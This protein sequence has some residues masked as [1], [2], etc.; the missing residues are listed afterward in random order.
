MITALAGLI[1]AQTASQTPTAPS[2]NLGTN[3][4]FQTQLKS[5]AQALS[6]GEFA[7]ATTAAQS[8]P[9]ANFTVQI[10]SE[11]LSPAEK[12]LTQSSLERAISAWQTAYPELKITLSDSKP[13][14]LISFVKRISEPNAAEE[15]SLALFP[16]DS[17][18]D[19]T[20]EAVIALQRGKTSALLDA[21]Q[22]TADIN[23]AIGQYLGLERSPVVAST[24]FRFEG[25]ANR[26]TKVDGESAFLASLNVLQAEQLRTWAKAKTTIIASFPEAFLREKSKDLGRFPQGEIKDFQFD[27]VNRGSGPLNFTIK[28]DCSCFQLAYDA[29]VP[30]NS[31]GIV[32]IRMH[33]AEFQGLQNKGLYFYTNDPSQPVTRVNIRADLVPAYRL[34]N[35]EN[36][37]DFLMS[38]NGLKTTYYIYGESKLGFE[39]R[40]ASIQGLNG[41]AEISPWTGE[42]EDP[43]LF[44]GKQ[45]VTGYKVE[46]L[47]SPNAPTGKNLVALIIRTDSEQFPTIA[48]N[49]TVQNGVAVTPATIF[50]GDVTTKSVQAS[51]I[52]TGTN[53]DFKVLESSSADS[54]FS[55][56][57]TALEGRN[58]RVEVTFQPGSTKGTIYSSVAL[59]TNDPKSPLITIPIQAYVK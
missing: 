27:V 48:A 59:K 18:T 25:L 5:T 3:E 34:I 20:L 6:Q 24:M 44:K 14:V 52:V 26:S 46:V 53:S 15:R 35:A 37:A 47:I 42:I 58:V 41:I 57:A 30:P 31:T 51:V 12:T 9:K 28:P 4:F 38:E 2:P 1:L 13:T 39:P 7:S 43:T 36:T 32:T 33:T 55:V 22:L 50:F 56:K 16:S 54:Q 10:S 21:N 8:L 40:K 23:Y 49:F 19:P 29:V 45:Q 11:N 17:P